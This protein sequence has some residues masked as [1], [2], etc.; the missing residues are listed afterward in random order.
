MPNVIFDTSPLQYLFQLDL[1]ELLP[2]M[3]GQ[4]VVPPAVVAELHAGRRLGQRLPI[5]E[6]LSWVRVES[7]ANP[8]MLLLAWDLGAGEREVLALAINQPGTLV[9]LDDKQARRAASNL[10]IDH[11]GTLGILLR[12]KA[13][14]LLPLLA[15]A[16]AQLTALGFRLDDTTRLAT[17][18]LA[19]ENST[20]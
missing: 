13:R 18:Q 16:L 12:A 6:E 4:I 10:G 3:M 11:T 14:G 1:I 5:V 15:P 17:L 7:I 19:G 9:V 8:G 20:D 2:E